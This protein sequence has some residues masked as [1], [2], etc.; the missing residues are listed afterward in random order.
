MPLLNIPAC[1]DWRLQPSKHNN[2]LKASRRGA[3]YKGN[4]RFLGGCLSELEEKAKSDSPRGILLWRRRRVLGSTQMFLIMTEL[5]I[6]PARCHSCL[7]DKNKWMECGGWTWANVML[8]KQLLEGHW[9]GD[10]NFISVKI[11]LSFPRL[12]RRLL[13]FRGLFAKVL[14]S[15]LVTFYN[16][17]NKKREW[18]GGYLPSSFLIKRNFTTSFLKYDL[19]IG[20]LDFE[21]L[22]RKISCSHVGVWIHGPLLAGL[23][24]VM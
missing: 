16:N 18:V 2:F 12:E 5:G 20:S 4:L 13:F 10:W 23:L 21:S 14:P 19:V 3:I 22:P 11:P 17:G 15:Q 9:D 8:A 1:C 7:G 6:C 24:W